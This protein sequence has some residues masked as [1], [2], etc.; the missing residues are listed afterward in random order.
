MNT[1]ETTA[2][3]TS[4]QNHIDDFWR[5]LEQEHV[6]ILVYIKRDYG[7]GIYFDSS[8]FPDAVAKALVADR[9]VPA[10][11]EAS[12]PVQGEPDA[13]LVEAIKF[14]ET[15]RDDYVS[16]HGNYDYSTGVTE[17]PGNGDEYVGELEEIIEGLEALRSQS[18]TAQ[19][20]PDDKPICW[21]PTQTVEWLQSNVGPACGNQTVAHIR[22]IKTDG[23]V[24]VYLRPQP[25]SA[26]P[27]VT[28]EA[29]ERASKAFHDKVA[30]YEGPGSPPWKPRHYVGWLFMQRMRAGL[31][32]AA[33]PQPREGWQTSVDITPELAERFCAAYWQN[34]PHDPPGTKRNLRD[35]AERALKITFGF[36]EVSEAEAPGRG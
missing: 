24:P 8:S 23:G 9:R 16:E 31:E 27:I 33:L 5:L 7:A 1:V 17:F 32:A 34:W 22:P 6:R 18:S 3:E 28:D 25:A 11:T 20:G 21:L 19:P 35:A 13:G 10:P 15:R 30:A 36:T 4:M 14:I 12:A 2:A 29:V 26:S